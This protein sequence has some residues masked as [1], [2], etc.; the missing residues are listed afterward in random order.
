MLGVGVATGVQRASPSAR[1][2]ATCLRVPGP[3]GCA[4]VLRHNPRRRRSSC[5]QPGARVWGQCV[6]PCAGLRCLPCQRS[7]VPAAAAAPE[8]RAAARVRQGMRGVECGRAGPPHTQG[9]LHPPARPPHAPTRRLGLLV[10]R[11]W[12]PGA[13]GGGLQVRWPGCALTARAQAT[14]RRTPAPSGPP[15]WAAACPASPCK[16]RGTPRCVDR[17]ARDPGWAR[18]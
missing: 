10:H 11:Y 13:P 9:V 3:Q 16:R 8:R 2:L 7:Q 6:V 12:W 4:R 17:G 14:A 5:C 15:A 1:P 18:P